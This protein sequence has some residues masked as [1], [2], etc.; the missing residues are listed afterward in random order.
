MDVLYFYLATTSAAGAV[1][2]LV[3]KLLLLTF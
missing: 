3:T 2:G 1:A